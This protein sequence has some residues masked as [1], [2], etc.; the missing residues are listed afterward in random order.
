MTTTHNSNLN[1]RDKQF[2]KIPSPNLAK[3]CD[4]V[5]SAY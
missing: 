1:R 4:S 2:H 5:Q 3:F